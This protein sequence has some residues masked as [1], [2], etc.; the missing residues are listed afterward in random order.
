[1]SQQRDE[2]LRRGLLSD[3]HAPAKWRVLGP[4]ANIPEFYAAFGVTPGQPM[5]RP[6]SLRVR[7]W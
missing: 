1:M 5:Y 3:V 2:S 4:L 7:I 6:D